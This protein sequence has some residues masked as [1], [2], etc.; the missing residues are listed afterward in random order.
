MSKRR[1]YRRKRFKGEGED[2]FEAGEN[3]NGNGEY[4]SEKSFFDNYS[5]F[6]RNN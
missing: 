1:N 6:V 3:E 2:W 5:I 4:P